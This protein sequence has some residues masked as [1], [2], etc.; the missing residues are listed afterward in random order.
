MGEGQKSFSFF[1]EN[2]GKLSRGK[3]PVAKMRQDVVSWQ[4]ISG[5]EDV[6][7]LERME[8]SAVQQ[9]MSIFIPILT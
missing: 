3:N 9:G 8:K 4:T 7:M 5:K 1:G 6:T 2:G